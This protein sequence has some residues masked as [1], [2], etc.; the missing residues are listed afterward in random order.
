MRWPIIIL[1]ASVV[2][3]FSGIIYYN[4]VSQERRVENVNL[5]SIFITSDAFVNNSVIPARYTCDGENISP[6]LSWSAEFNLTKSFAIIMEDPDAPFGT[7]LHWFIVNI[8]S[9]IRHLP[10]GLNASSFNDRL[11]QL[12]NDFGYVGYG[13][14]CPP[15]GSTHHYIITIYALDIIL[16]TTTNKNEA[17]LMIRDHAIAKGTLIALYRR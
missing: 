2:I 6:S 3:A 7:F 4:M 10:E 8:P 11:V 16:P 12:K 5:A 17:M 1:V 14:P 15:K 13:G 9:D